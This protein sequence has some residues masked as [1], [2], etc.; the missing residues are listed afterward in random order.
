MAS[1]PDAEVRQSHG[2]GDPSLVMHVSSPGIRNMYVVGSDPPILEREPFR[3]YCASWARALVLLV[4][5][6]RRRL[7]TDILHGR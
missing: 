1:S 2:T 6:N 3:R 7:L 4:R 5:E